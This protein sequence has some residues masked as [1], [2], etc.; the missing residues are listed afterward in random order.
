M[1]IKQSETSYIPSYAAPEKIQPITNIKNIGAE[2]INISVDGITGTT[3]EEIAG[4][5]SKKIKD[6]LL[7]DED[8]QNTFSRKIGKKI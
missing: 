4:Q 2:N 3:P 1:N 5:V 6:E 7:T 8:F